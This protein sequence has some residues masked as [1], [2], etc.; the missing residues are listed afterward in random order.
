[1]R[2][3]RM[4]RCLQEALRPRWAEVG[5]HFTKAFG[6]VLARFRS[7]KARDRVQ[8]WIHQVSVQV[9]GA[10]TSAVLVWAL[11]RGR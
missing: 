1:M 7:F 4:W 10:T 8:C 6:A 5:G 11:T 2:P 3:A 9:V